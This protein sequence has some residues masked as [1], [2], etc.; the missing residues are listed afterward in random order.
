MLNQKHCRRKKRRISRSIFSIDTHAA[1][2]LELM[3]TEASHRREIEE[4]CIALDK[5]RF[6]ESAAARKDE[7]AMRRLAVEAQKA[8][9][10][11][12]AAVVKRLG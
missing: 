4:C 10:K 8:L 1:A 6:Q 5:K 2:E 9:A 7:L 3:K 12:L 11:S